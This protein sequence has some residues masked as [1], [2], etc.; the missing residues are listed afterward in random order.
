M[1][2]FQQYFE[3]SWM[4]KP[5]YDSTRSDTNWWAEGLE[6]PSDLKEFDSKSHEERM[7]EVQCHRTEERCLPPRMLERP[8]NRVKIRFLMWSY[9]RQID[10]V[11]QPFAMDAM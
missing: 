6:I 3:N 2:D 11:S 1:F 4:L 7:A 9:P 5:L 10:V 8:V